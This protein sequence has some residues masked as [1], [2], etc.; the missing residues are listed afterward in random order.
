MR[1]EEGF[2]FCWDTISKKSLDFLLYSNTLVAFNVQ[3]RRLIKFAMEF[4]YP[5]SFGFQFY[6]TQY[7][8]RRNDF[9]RNQTSS[10]IVDE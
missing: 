6:S 10:A 9:C 8:I 2:K 5:I 1:Q 4:F 3:L 7:I